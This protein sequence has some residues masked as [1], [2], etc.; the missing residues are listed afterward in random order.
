MAVFTWPAYN[1]YTERPQFRTLKSKFENGVAQ[2]RAKWAYPLRIFVLQFVMS[3]WET[4][5]QEIFDFF[6]A[7]KGG[8]EAFEWVN[9]NDD[10][11]Y[12]VTFVED[13]VDL[14]RFAYN[15]YSLGEIRLI[16]DR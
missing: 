16:E 11:T 9:P 15:L 7:R 13:F 3:D 5:A 4:Q 10:T 2:R 14:A 12:N 6:I 1:I 8:Y